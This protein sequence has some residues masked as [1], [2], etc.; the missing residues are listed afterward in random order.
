MKNK[1]NKHCFYTYKSECFLVEMNITSSDTGWKQSSLFHIN[2]LGRKMAYKKTTAVALE[3]CLSHLLFIS[4]LVHLISFGGLYF[5]H[6]HAAH[7]T[8]NGKHIY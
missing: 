6:V 1:F 2:S 7:F 3:S 8:N 4:S 5:I